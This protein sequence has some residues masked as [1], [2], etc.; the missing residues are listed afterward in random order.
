MSGIRSAW[1]QES[2]SKH[3]TIIFLFCQHGW[4]DNPFE[5]TRC[6]TAAQH[7]WCRHKIH[8]ARKQEFRKHELPEFL[9]RLRLLGMTIDDV[10]KAWEERQD[11]KG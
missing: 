4:F 6:D 8:I 11:T 2:P 5:T 9:R 7:A 3:L 1:L 10:V